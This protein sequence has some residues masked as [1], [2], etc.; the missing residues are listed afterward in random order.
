MGKFVKKFIW[1]SAVLVLI[2]A[3]SR[4][5]RI[6]AILMRSGVPILELLDLTSRTC[7]NVIIARAINQIKASVDQGKGMAEPMKVSGVFAPV[8]VS[9]V[10]VGEQIGKVDELLLNV[11]DYYDKETEYAIKNLIYLNFIFI[12]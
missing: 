10:A 9:M 5:S 12:A 8:V 7:S 1:F 4:F 2:I 11:A 6:T 3:M